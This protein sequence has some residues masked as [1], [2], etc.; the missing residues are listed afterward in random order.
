MEL[1][2]LQK[3][4]PEHS[5]F[6]SLSLHTDRH[7]GKAMGEQGEIARD[8]KPNIKTQ[9]CWHPD[10]RLPAFRTVRINVVYKPPSL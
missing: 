6:L 4:T 1:A 5:L 2:P 8:S 7:Q 10:L 3:E 9:P